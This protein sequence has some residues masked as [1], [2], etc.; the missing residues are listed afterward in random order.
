MALI[1]GYMGMVTKLTTWS[2][3]GYQGFTIDKSMIKKLFSRK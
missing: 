3:R 2:L 1:G